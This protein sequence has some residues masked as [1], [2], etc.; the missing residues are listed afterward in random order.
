[1]FSLHVAKSFISSRVLTLHDLLLPKPSHKLRR[2]LRNDP[3]PTSTRQ[4]SAAPRLKNQLI[5]ILAPSRHMLAFPLALAEVDAS[6]VGDSLG[7][8]TGG[9]YG[10]VL[11]CYGV[12]GSDVL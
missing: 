9:R 2:S 4:R 12:L 6:E 8:F 3:L 5:Y 11:G 10:E 7:F 1:M